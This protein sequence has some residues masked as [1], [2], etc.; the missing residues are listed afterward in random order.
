MKRAQEKKISPIIDLGQYEDG[1]YF[2]SLAAD[3]KKRLGFI[4]FLHEILDKLSADGFL[5]RW[6]FPGC[7][8]V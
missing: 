6:C 8:S 3:R 5:I 1:D 4:S 7:P 2:A